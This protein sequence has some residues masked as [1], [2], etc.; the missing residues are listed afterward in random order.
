M[1]LRELTVWEIALA[2]EVFGAALATARARL[3]FHRLPSPFAVTLGRFVA[4]P[5]RAI[6]DFAAEPVEAQAWLIHELTHVWQFQTAPGKTLASWATLLITGGYG[7]GAPGYRYTLPTHWSAL[8][9][10]QQ[11]AV[12]E[13]KF[14][15][16]RGLAVRFGPLGARPGDY[17]GLTPFPITKSP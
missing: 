6:D 12:V 15:L 17:A 1:T 2:R 7:Q 13:D 14:R 5:G 4:L 11:A 16:D 10:E 8:N 3:V 9:L